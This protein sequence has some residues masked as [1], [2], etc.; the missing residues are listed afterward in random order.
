MR[1]SRRW[2][3]WLAGAGAALMIVLV[4]LASIVPLRSQTL[5]AR[6]VATL[7]DRLNSDVT[8]DELSVKAFPRLHVEGRGLSIRQRNR[9]DDVPPLIA[10]KAFEV[11]ADLAGVARKHVSHVE[12]TGLEISI[13]PKPDGEPPDASTPDRTREHRL[14]PS[15]GAVATIGDDPTATKPRVDPASLE[16]GVVI[17]QL[18][19]RDARLVIIPRKAGKQPRVWAIHTLRMRDVGVSQAMPYDA[20][21]TNGVPPGEIVTNGRFGPWNRG[22]PGST[23]LE[24]TFTFDKAD[25]G[26]FN[27]IGGTLSSRGSFDGALAYIEVHGE[28]D[29]PDFVVNVGGHPFP[30]HTNY[31][32]IVDGTTGDTRLERIDATFLRSTLV[33]K[34]AVLD[35]PPGQKGRTVSLDITMPQARIEDVMLMAVHTPTPPMSGALRLTTKF[36]LPPGETDVVERLRLN[37]RFT[38]TRAKFTNYDVQG[39]IVEL[40]YRG[41]G[42]ADER[43]TEPVASDFEGRFAFA[44]G[45]L[46]LPDVTFG[47][48]GAQVKLAGV[49][50][51]KR[52]SLAFK[53]HLFLDAKVSQTVTGI[54]S[55]LLKVVDPLFRRKGG[56]S[57]IPIKIEGTRQDPKFGLDMGRVFRKGD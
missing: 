28:T 5:K 51:V 38:I 29:T 41:R 25:L 30:L 45:R 37:G 57:A 46:E 21:L 40:S 35:G 36:L 56:G 12:L 17:D 43:R 48:P 54:K 42:K 26:V 14:H 11:D 2:A 39:K 3:W 20:T 44:D 53:G 27:G 10:I 1:L 6:I 24:G 4:I 19:T 16:G 33:A 52:E 55:L 9:T 32:A 7:A 13:P 31:H 49:Y 22:D 18:D 15:T 47:V 23:P 8:L 50:A 34:G